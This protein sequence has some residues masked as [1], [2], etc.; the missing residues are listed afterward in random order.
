MLTRHTR[1]LKVIARYGRESLEKAEEWKF[2][3]AELFMKWLEGT[4]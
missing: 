4:E 3:S 2:H 1:F